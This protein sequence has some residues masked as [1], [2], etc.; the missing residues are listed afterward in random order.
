MENCEQCKEEMIHCDC[1]ENA[2][3]R[4]EFRMAIGLRKLLKMDPREDPDLIVYMKR[5]Y[6][7]TLLS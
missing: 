4:V 7:Q 6:D 2:M 1:P 3:K 5:E